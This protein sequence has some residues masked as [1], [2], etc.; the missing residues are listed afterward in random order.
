[1]GRKSEQGIDRYGHR[2]IVGLM[3]NERDIHCPFRSP[4]DQ[5]YPGLENPADKFW[6]KLFF[7]TATHPE[8]K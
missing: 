4:E 5:A 6:G 8:E 1:M 3:K 2:N 7:N